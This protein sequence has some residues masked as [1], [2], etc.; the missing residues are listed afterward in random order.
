MFNKPK[1]IVYS[2]AVDT[3]INDKTEK[4][5]PF[6]KEEL[7]EDNQDAENQSVIQSSPEKN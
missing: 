6:N 1:F 5:N 7:V 3:S 4:V 2:D